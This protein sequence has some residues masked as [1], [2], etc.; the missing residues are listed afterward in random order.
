MM[1]I[2]IRCL[3]AA[4]LVAGV[5]VAQASTVTE[6]NIVQDDPEFGDSFGGSV[7]I[8]GTTVIVGSASDDDGGL[9]SGSVYLFDAATGAQIN[10]LTASDASASARFGS[11]VAID[12][13]IA[14]VG[15]RDDDGLGNQA[16]AVYVFDTETGAELSRLTA[17]DASDFDLL[18]ASVDISGSTII[19]TAPGD[20]DL[21]ESSGFF[22]SDSGAAYLFDAATGTQIAK[23]TASDGTTGDAFGGGPRDGNAVAIDGNLAIVGALYHDG[24]GEDSG[25]AYVFDATTGS[26]VA[27]LTPSDAAAGDFFGSSVDI[28]GNIA[29][30]G[31]PSDDDGGSR[32]GSV[33]LFDAATGAQLAKLTAT[34]A[35]T[36][37]NFGWSVAL[38]GD[39]AIIGAITDRGTLGSAYIFDITDGTQLRK[40]F[41]SDSL[42]QDRFGGA[43]DIFG[44]IAV[45]GTQQGDA[46]SFRRDDGTFAGAF[47]FNAIDGSW[48]LP[49]PPPGCI[50][51]NF[52]P[53]KCEPFR[54][55]VVPLPA[56]LP[57]LLAGLGGLAFL[58]KRHH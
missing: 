3:F 47:I 14:V 57:L 32:S 1:Y 39:I 26:Q 44:D 24:A 42:T 46:T 52:T 55:A 18:G 12:G 53:P 9:R 49:Q 5:G 38:S 4:I 10:K 21:G 7:A 6:T 36:G 31:A 30:V 17:D 28:Q 23:L 15:A 29:I 13:T 54:P 16:G 51:S 58:R 56:G 20:D 41:P 11:S 8:Y 22:G 43:V 40:L 35:R 2:Y 33:Y 25:A 19:A 50:P 45:V 48:E 37:A 34:D 27:K